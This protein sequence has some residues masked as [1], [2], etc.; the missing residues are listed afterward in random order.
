MKNE[1]YQDL[2]GIEGFRIGKPEYKL[3]S[4]VPSGGIYTYLIRDNKVNTIFTYQ[5]LDMLS[6]TIYSKE[7][8][9]ENLDNG[10]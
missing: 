1:F 2:L 8:V 4:Y 3:F 9:N 7:N 5:D 6:S 10:S